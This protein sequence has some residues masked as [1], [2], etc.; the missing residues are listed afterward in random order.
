[1]A[2]DEPV[3]G[4]CEEPRGPA[5]VEVGVG[6]DSRDGDSLGGIGYL[7]DSDSDFR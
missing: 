6:V 1:M 5:I 7:G 2:T 4:R 3:D